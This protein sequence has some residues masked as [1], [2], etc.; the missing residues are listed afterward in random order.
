MLPW[1]SFPPGDASSGRCGAGNSPRTRRGRGRGAGRGR[2]ARPADPRDVLEHRVVVELALGLVREH[3]GGKP[4][5]TQ[6]RRA[7][8]P[9]GVLLPEGEQ[10]LDAASVQVGVAQRP[11]AT[12]SGD[13][14][15]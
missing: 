15:R 13:D 2:A 14:C 12:V 1:A 4:R 7:G 6:H 3:S 11:D 10:R 8:R 5:R 9:A